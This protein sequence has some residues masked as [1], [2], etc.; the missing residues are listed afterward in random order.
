MTKEKEGIFKKFIHD[1]SSDA[2][3]GITKVENSAV[4]LGN[5]THSIVA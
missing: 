5:T 3:H 2:E 1:M 4:I